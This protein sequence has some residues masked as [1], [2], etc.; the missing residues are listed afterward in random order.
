MLPLLIYGQI[1]CVFQVCMWYYYY[2]YYYNTRLTAFFQ[3][4]VWG[5]IIQQKTAEVIQ[6]LKTIGNFLCVSAKH[7]QLVR[8]G[9]QQWQPLLAVWHGIYSVWVSGGWHRCVVVF[10]Q[11]TINCFG[12]V[13]SNG[14]R[15][16][17]CDMAGRLFMLL[18]DYEVADDNKHVV[19]D[20][21][22]ELLGEVVCLHSELFTS[23][24][25]LA[26]KMSINLTAVRRI[27][28]TWPKLM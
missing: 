1:F 22:V 4:V 14:S 21:K 10:Q 12:A 13:D 17:L 2:Y 26:W 16:L 9:G 19:R 7:S 8:C 25:L 24:W 18:L 20:L 28:G 27:L 15:Y 11:S 3:V 23:G 6:L 5:N